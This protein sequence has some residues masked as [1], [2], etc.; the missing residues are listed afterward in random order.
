MPVDS[1]IQK[2]V[3]D[4]WRTDNVTFERESGIQN[5][6]KSNNQE[7]SRES[8]IVTKKAITKKDIILELVF[9]ILFLLFY[10]IHRLPFFRRCYLD[11]FLILK[12][13]R[14]SFAIQFFSNFFLFLPIIKND[15]GCFHFFW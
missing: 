12:I 14:F 3:I 13:Y 1:S 5:P 8:G 11:M 10:C 4:G 2:R 7:S 15:T 6:T 9:L